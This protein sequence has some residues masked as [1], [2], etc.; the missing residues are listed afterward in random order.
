[1]LGRLIRFK[2]YWSR[3]AFYESIV[4]ALVLLIF[5]YKL[6]EDDP[7]GVWLYDNRLI[8]IPIVVLGYIFYRLV[9]GYL[10]KRFIRRKETDEVTETNPRFMEMYG[11][12]NK[13]YKKTFELDD[14]VG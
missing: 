10:D 1:M 4:K 14:K 13:I 9:V 2:V 6:W 11:K 7:L 5:V 8:V 12:V 3:S